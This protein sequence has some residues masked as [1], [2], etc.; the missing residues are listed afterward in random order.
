MSPCDELRGAQNSGPACRAVPKKEGG[1]VSPSATTPL[2]LQM[3]CGV[4]A[5]ELLSSSALSSV[6]HPYATK[7]A[8]SRAS[9]GHVRHCAMMYP[10]SLTSGAPTDAPAAKRGRKEPARSCSASGGRGASPRTAAAR[11]RPGWYRG[12]EPQRRRGAAGVI[13]RASKARAALA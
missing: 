5:L 7:G 11:P 8:T 3:I 9:L 12:A 2:P 10:S 13:E 6:T 1:G 4:S